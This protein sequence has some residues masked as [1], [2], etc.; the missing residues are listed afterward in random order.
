MLNRY[1]ARG[2]LTALLTGASP[3]LRI[4]VLCKG[5]R[6]SLVPGV[7]VRGI[8]LAKFPN[9]VVISRVF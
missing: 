5:R 4:R 3:H 7:I 1:C 8:T 9:V 6:S 2:A